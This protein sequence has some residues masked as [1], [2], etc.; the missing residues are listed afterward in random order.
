[1][2][3][4]VRVGGRVRE[5]VGERVRFRVVLVRRDLHQ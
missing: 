4:V 5:W 1:M 3:E 2:G